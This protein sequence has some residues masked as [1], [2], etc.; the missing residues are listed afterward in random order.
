MLF[1]NKDVDTHNDTIYEATTT[2]KAE[3]EA[4]D[5]VIGD[6]TPEVAEDIKLRHLQRHVMPW[7]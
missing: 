3:M 2:T 1:W 5:I 7:D 6:I 4:R